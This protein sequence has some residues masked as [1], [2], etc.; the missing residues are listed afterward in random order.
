[1]VVIVAAFL[2]MIFL[3]YGITIFTTGIEGRTEDKLKE[4]D[5]GIVIKVDVDGEY[6]A[7]DIEEY[8]IGVLPGQIS[9]KSNIEAMKA[10]AVIV[11]T[12][13]LKQ[14]GENKT[15][16]SENLQEE[17]LEDKEQRNIWGEL[18]YDKYKKLIEKAVLDTKGQ[19]LRYNGEYIEPLYHQVSS[20]TTATA[21]EL[22]ENGAEYLVG[23]E[24]KDD[25]NSKDYLTMYTFPL[26]KIN[27]QFGCNI[28]PENMA[29]SFTIIESTPSGYVKKVKICD[30][31]YSS[32][33][34]EEEKT[35]W[36]FF[37]IIIQE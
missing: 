28:T 30:N 5:S 1:M 21:K 20:G 22:Y 26:A 13:I 6:R 29:E 12:S 24:S 37:Y 19:V 16:D 17:Y 25:V 3:P 9:P 11:R 4:L 15:F 23:V 36:T 14:M 7:M 32:Q 34:I 18:H 2:V 10:Q 27:E 35:I 8:I 31:E 33:D